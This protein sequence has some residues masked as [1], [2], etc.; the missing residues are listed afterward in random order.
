[1]RCSPSSRTS[2]YVERSP[3]KPRD[4]EGESQPAD[5]VLNITSGWTYNRLC[6]DQHNRF[7]ERPGET[8]PGKPGHRAPGRLNIHGELAGLGYRIGAQ[9]L[10]FLAGLG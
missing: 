3:A 4:G 9:D 7:G 1:M 5:P 8:E 2:D 10:D 6:G